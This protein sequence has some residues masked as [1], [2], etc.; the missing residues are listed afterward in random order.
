MGLA[1]DHLLYE[2]CISEVLQLVHADAIRNGARLQW[3][4]YFEPSKEIIKEFE[5][6]TSEELPDLW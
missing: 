5:L 2:T 3:K 1:P 6:L 4:H